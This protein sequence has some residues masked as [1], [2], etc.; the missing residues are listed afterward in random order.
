MIYRYLK[1]SETMGAYDNNSTIYL[2]ATQVP[3]NLI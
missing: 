3:R 2:N 1:E